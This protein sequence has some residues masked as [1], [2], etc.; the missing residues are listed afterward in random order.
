M[1]VFLTFLLL[2]PTAAFALTD[3]E[4]A[5]RCQLA[6]ITKVTDQARVW[7]CDLADP[8]TVTGIDNRPENPAKYI[9]FSAPVRH[10]TNG[11]TTVQKMVQYYDGNC[12]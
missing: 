9:W 1:K 5:A 3:N 4:I 2:F 10:C 8:V 6:G 11:E 7:N 12:Y